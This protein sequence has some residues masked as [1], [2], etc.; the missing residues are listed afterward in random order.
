MQSLNVPIALTHTL[1]SGQLFRY[2][3]EGAGYRITHGR[4][5]F[6]VKGEE[7][8]DKSSRQI[9][10][11]G[12]SK[13]S[14]ISFFRLDDDYEKI[15]EKIN[16][17]KTIAQALQKYNG[18]RLLRQDPWECTISFLCS[19]ATNIPRIKRDIDNIAKVFGEEKEGIFLFPKVGEMNNQKKI[20]G[21]GTGFRAKYIYE[22]NNTVTASFFKNLKKKSYEDAK[23]AL[24]ELPGIGPKVADCIL[25]FSLDHL[26]AFPV[27]TWMEKVMLQHYNEQI[28]QQTKKQKTN[29]DDIRSFSQNYFSPYAGYAQQFLYHWVRHEKDRT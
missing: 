23:A 18:L 29:A 27:D 1:D 11:K 13:A 6:F 7:C 26:N 16:K 3:K 8:D 14:F 24:M 21:C 10:F 4:F 25:L 22:V 19:S 5:S 9:Q 20:R 2:R 17:D 15:K 12:I 28:K